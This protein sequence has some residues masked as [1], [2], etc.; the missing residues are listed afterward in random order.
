MLMDRSHTAFV[1]GWGF[2]YL[3]RVRGIFGVRVT[4]RVPTS[5]TGVASTDGDLWRCSITLA[6]GY[7]DKCTPWTKRGRGVQWF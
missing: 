2:F 1:L 6:T 3:Q 4:G 5:G 7:K